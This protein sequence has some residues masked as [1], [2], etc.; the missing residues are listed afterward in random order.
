MS[1]Y[2]LLGQVTGRMNKEAN[3]GI[4]RA[5][6]ELSRLPNFVGATGPGVSPKDLMKAYT[7]MGRRLGRAMIEGKSPIGK[8][9][10]APFGVPKKAP[11]P[12]AQ[13]TVAVDQ[14]AKDIASNFGRTP[15]TKETHKQLA[16]ILKKFRSQAAGHYK[17]SPTIRTSFDP[18]YF[19]SIEHLS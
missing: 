11:L 15:L 9:R 3:A 19:K 8:I 18:M 16:P 7:G 5:L 14:L 1:I 6:R 13:G 12:M 17:V 10:S 4:F 2:N